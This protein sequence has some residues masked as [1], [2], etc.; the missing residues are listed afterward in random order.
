MNCI[1]DA[2]TLETLTAKFRDLKHVGIAGSYSTERTVI[3]SISKFICALRDVETLVVGHLDS[4]AFSHVARFPR[5]R[6]L[7]LMSDT[8]TPY[9]QPPTDLPHFP[10]LRAL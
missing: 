3:P 1:P 5:L 4:M 2:L 9:L 10:T 6:Y 8:A 7:W